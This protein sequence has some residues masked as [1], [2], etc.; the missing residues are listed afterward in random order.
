MMRL[1]TGRSLGV[2]VMGNATAYDHQRI[3]KAVLEAFPG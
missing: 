2:I 3:A 1:F